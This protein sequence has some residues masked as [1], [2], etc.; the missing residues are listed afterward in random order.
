MAHLSLLKLAFPVDE[1]IRHIPALG[2]YRD[3]TVYPLC[4]SRRRENLAGFRM[5]LFHFASKRSDDFVSQRRA[6][7]DGQLTIAAAA[8]FCPTL[9]SLN[10]LFMPQRIGGQA[11]CLT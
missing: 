3:I 5:R 7:T 9:R 1:L 8:P 2:A 10:V 11:N 6:N 4:P